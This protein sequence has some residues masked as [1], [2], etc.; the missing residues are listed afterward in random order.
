MNLFL[1]ISCILISVIV[2]QSHLININELIANNFLSIN[3][4]FA[5]FLF[6]SLGIIAGVLDKDII[7]F[8]DKGGYLDSYINGIVIGLVMHLLSA[9][10]ELIL[11]N[12]DLPIGL[13]T[14]IFI[15]KAIFLLLFIGIVFFVKSMLNILKLIKL[16]R[17]Q[18]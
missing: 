12:I 4:I 14:E 5:G 10:L 7:I 11:S 16:I 3:A 2:I 6:T 18:T 17:Q 8:L 9:I 13:Q 1:L 15:D